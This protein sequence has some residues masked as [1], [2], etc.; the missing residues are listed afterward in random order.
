MQMAAA[1][2]MHFPHLTLHCSFAVEIA[3]FLA[4]R[5]VAV[6]CFREYQE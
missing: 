3:G 1:L 2:K 6:K 5:R 4:V